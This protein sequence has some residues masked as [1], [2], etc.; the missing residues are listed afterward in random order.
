MP[1]NLQPSDPHLASFPRPKDDNGRG[2]HFVLDSRDPLVEQYAPYLARMQM[3]WATVYG[4][5]ELQVTR[6]ASYLLVNYG[7]FSNMRVQATG[8]KAKAPS[9]WQNLAQLSVRAGVPPYIQIFNEPEVG[10]EGFGNPQ[11]FADRWGA[12]AEAVVAGGGFPGLQVLSE[13]FLAAVLVG[14]SDAVKNKM[15]FCLHNYGSNH[16]PSY[17]YPDQTALDDD[18]TVLRF[19]AFEAW[20]KKYLGFVPPMIGGEGG[21]LYQ[22][23][24]DKTMP[25]VTIDKWVDWH[26]E[27]YEWFRSGILSNGDPLPDYLFSVTPWLLYASNWYGDSWVDGLDSNLKAELIDKLASDQPYVRMFAEQTLSPALSFTPPLSRAPASPVLL[28]MTT[29]PASATPVT[30]SGLCVSN[31]P[32]LQGQNDLYSTRWG[33]LVVL[34]LNK[35]FVPDLRAHS[36]NAT[37]VM[38]AY[39]P[40]WY[41]QDPVQWAQQIAAWAAELRPYTS[42][43]T[44]ANEQNLAGEGHPNGAPYNGSPFPPRQVYADINTWNLKVI[45]TLRSLVPWLRIHWPALSQGHSDDSAD[46]GYVGFEICRPSIEAC[47]VLDVHTYWNIGDPNGS[48]ESP[49]Y[50]RRYEKVRALFPNMPLY[51]SEY[52]GTFPNDPRAPAEYKQWLDGL[53][54]YIS[55]AAAFIWDSDSA[56]SAWRIYNQAP[57]VKMLASYVPPSPPPPPVTSPLTDAALAHLVVSQR[58]M[59]PEIAIATILAESGGNPGATHSEGN[60]PPSTDRGLW[61]INCVE[62]QTPVLCADLVWRQ[63]GDLEAG[64]EIIAVDESPTPSLLSGLRHGRKFRTTRV[65]A[66]CCH[67]AECFRVVTTLGELIATANHPWLFWSENSHRYTWKWMT[68]EQLQVGTPVSYFKEPWKAEAGWEAGWLAGMYDG[69]GSYSFGHSR[70]KRDYADAHALNLAQRPSQ[71]L[72]RVREA[73][74][75]RQFRVNETTTHSSLGAC[76]TL[77]IQCRPEIMRLL[78]M[79]RPPRLLELPKLRQLWEGMSVGKTVQRAKVIA[80]EKLPKLKEIAQLQIAART[81]LA[82]GF[83]AHNSYWHSEVTDQCAFDPQCSTRAAFT[84][85]KWGTDYTPWTAYKAGTYKQFL[86]RARAALSAVQPPSPQPGELFIDP[87]ITWVTVNQGTQYRVAQVWFYDNMPPNDPESENGISIYAL[88]RDPSG[89]SQ[90]HEAVRQVWPTGYS[91]HYTRNG[92]VSFQM[93]Q[94][95]NFDPQKGAG[96]YGIYVGDAS[97]A[98]FGLP[99]NQHVEYLIVVVKQSGIA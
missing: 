10:R 83:I 54:D 43:W 28:S 88:V 30:R 70:G 26:H 25:P 15:Y 84:I 91:T 59:Q 87:R 79:I 21:W 17:P 75:R 72:E 9:F 60:K 36:S 57:L 61:Q 18:T 55:G 56:N 42:D 51:I 73:L 74:I 68:T 35:G 65:E 24:D 44:F 11:Q 38:R 19:L 32:T 82:N 77:V 33:S 20:F 22:D 2:L 37:I 63:V 46:A 8:D 39:T 40:N 71:T 45:Q 86:A 89:Q 4:G 7:I 76:Q 97:V 62:A 67:P 49:L 14:V 58:F 95:S 66:N 27:M 29:S 94:D 50:G 69:E 3:K 47:D 41:T 78:G 80:V 53:P 13:D 52:G 96:P 85:S 16:P 98:G 92:M 6:T 64:D 48:V 1:G 90:E 5:D 99:L 93:G 12:R 31:T 34:H 23:S 81:Y